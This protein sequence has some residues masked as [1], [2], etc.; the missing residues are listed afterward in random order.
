M[1]NLTSSDKCMHLPN[2]HANQGMGHFHQ[3]RRCLCV[4]LHFHS[5]PTASSRSRFWGCRTLVGASY[6][7]HDALSSELYERHFLVL[8][9]PLTSHPQ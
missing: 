5:L 1:Y 9:L 3:L 6:E 7:I 2:Y 8:I 4:R